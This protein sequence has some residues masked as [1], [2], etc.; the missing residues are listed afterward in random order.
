[1]A[2]TPHSGSLTIPSLT[3]EHLSSVPKRNSDVF[4][5]AYRREQR[6]F[7]QLYA[8]Y[9]RT[10]IKSWTAPRVDSTHTS[11]LPAA[12]PSKGVDNFVFGTPV[13]KARVSKLPF[14]LSAIHIERLNGAQ[15]EHAESSKALGAQRPLRSKTS[16]SLTPKPTPALHAVATHD[17]TLPGF[18]PSKSPKPRKRSP[19]GNGNTDEEHENRWVF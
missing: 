4:L 3:L 8:S 9:G 10:E 11:D 18:K 12:T 7:L 14:N 6:Q 13:L 5:S 16:R 2:L 17:K 15:L 1:M 19:R